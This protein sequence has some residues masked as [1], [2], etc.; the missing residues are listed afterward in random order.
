MTVRT[1]TLFMTI[2]EYFEKYLFSI[3]KEKHNDSFPTRTHIIFE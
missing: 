1:H 3:E 2:D